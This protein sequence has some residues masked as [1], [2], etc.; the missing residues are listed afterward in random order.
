[1]VFMPFSKS[2]QSE[3]AVQASKNLWEKNFK[4]SET[5]EDRKNFLKQFGW[6]I[7]T[8]AYDVRLV[9][10]PVQ[11]DSIYKKY[12]DLQIREGLNLEK[13]KGKT[14]KKYTYLVN[15]H[16]YNGIVY[17]NLLVYKNQ[18]IGG[19]LSSA[20]SGGFLHGFSKENLFQA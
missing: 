7:E 2:D 1:M 10:I 19:D 6:E 5:A 9:T 13:Y 4:N 12:N 8:E 15:N 14:V 18:V 20:V 16:E 3:I 11:F 17:A